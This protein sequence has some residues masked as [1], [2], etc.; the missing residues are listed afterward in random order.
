[1]LRDGQVTGV[2][3]ATMALEQASAALA[4]L[5][6]PDG[7][8][9][10]VIDRHERVLIEHPVQTG[11]ELPRQMARS[12]LLDAVRTLASGVGEGADPAGQ[13]RIYAY[14]PSKGLDGE[15]FIAVVSID[16]AR[17]ASGSLTSLRQELLVLAATLLIGIA[18]AWW[19]GGRAIVRPAG[20][21]LDAVRRRCARTRRAGER[22]AS[23]CERPGH[24][25]PAAAPVAAAVRPLSR[26]WHQAVLAGGAAGGAGAAR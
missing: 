25:L 13:A 9:V 1:V 6:L 7:A 2:V 20:Q 18:G 3:F 22:R 16:K 21:I 23:G 5:Q 12:D 24:P 10:M 14:S 4:R 15:G 8:R 17:I 26:R 11:R 19:V